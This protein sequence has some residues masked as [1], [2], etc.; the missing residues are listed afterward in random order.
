MVITFLAH[1]TREI[2]LNGWNLIARDYLQ[3]LE[4]LPSTF[5]PIATPVCV[6]FCVL[7]CVLT[8]HPLC[9][10][11]CYYLFTD[12]L[13]QSRSWSG[14][15]MQQQKKMEAAAFTKPH[16]PPRDSSAEPA[17]RRKPKVRSGDRQHRTPADAHLKS[18]RGKNV[19]SYLLQRTSYLI[20]WCCISLPL[21]FIL[22]SFDLM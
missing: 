13:N 4:S 19:N 18:S 7:T 22:F 1:F 12:P 16:P 15:E 5:L 11:S 10:M 17:Q 9:L 2:I 8:S 3:T 14:A 20:A 6:I 21:E